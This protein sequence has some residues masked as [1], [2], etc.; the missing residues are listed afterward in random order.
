MRDLGATIHYYEH[1]A[2]AGD[3][4]DR[5]KLL[6]HT[7]AHLQDITTMILG[8]VEGLL[9]NETRYIIIINIDFLCVGVDQRIEKLQ[10]ELTTLYDCPELQQ[11]Q[12]CHIHA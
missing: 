8:K 12:V 10:A 1:V 11:Y 5:Q 2:N 4:P 9:F 3:N 7:T 6:K